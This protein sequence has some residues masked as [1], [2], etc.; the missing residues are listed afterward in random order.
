M[1]PKP[2][3]SVVSQP[4]TD[5]GAA[6]SMMRQ[7]DCLGQPARRPWAARWPLTWA[8]TARK[9]TARPAKGIWIAPYFAW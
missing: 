2:L 1:T 4:N 7:D 9:N 6:L 3:A 5:I 8:G